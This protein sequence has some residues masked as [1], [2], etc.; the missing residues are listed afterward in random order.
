MERS[1]PYVERGGAI[2]PDRN[3]NPDARSRGENGGLEYEKAESGREGGKAAHPLWK[4]TYSPTETVIQ[5]PDLGV[6]MGVWNM[7]KLLRDGGWK[8]AQRAQSG[9]KRTDS[10]TETRIQTPGLGAR[11]GVWNMRY[12]GRDEGGKRRAQGLK[13]RPYSQMETVIQ[14]PDLG[15]R[16]GVW[17]IRKLLR[18][19]GWKEAR[20]RWKEAEL[21]SQTETRIQTPG[22]GARTDGKAESAREGGKRCTHCLK[23]RTY[24]RTETAI[25]NPDL[26]V[27]MGG[28]EHERKIGW[29]EAHPMCKEADLPP[30]GNQNPDPRSGARTGSGI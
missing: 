27:R 22:L 6:R 21:Y 8:E 15:V 2:Q 17:N 30:N 11:T 25:Q 23:K 5:N 9:K 24:N 26:G 7:R 19:G 10:Q 28:L 16:R 3:H 18:D 4:R 12:S 13:K 1:A 29:E 14:N 20:P